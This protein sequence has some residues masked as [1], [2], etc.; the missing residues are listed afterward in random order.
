MKRGPPYPL[1]D[2]SIFMHFILLKL[3]LSLVVFSTELAVLDVV[4]GHLVVWQ[5]ICAKKKCIFVGLFFSSRIKV[6]VSLFFIFLLM[7]YGKTI[8][9][10]GS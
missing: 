7:L 8:H 2:A 9:G 6:K 10:D 4:F 5:A 1:R 3:S